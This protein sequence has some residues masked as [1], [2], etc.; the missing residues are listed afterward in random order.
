MLIDD[1]NIRERVHSARDIHRIIDA[2]HDHQ[3]SKPD[4]V[5]AYALELQILIGARRGEIPPLRREDIN[6]GCI[7]IWQEQ[8]TVKAHDGIPEKDLI[9]SHTKTGKNRA[10]PIDDMTQDLLDRLF[11]MLDEYYPDTEY[12]F[13]ANTPNGVISNATV[14][15]FYYRTC[16]KLGIKISRETVKGTHSFRRNAITSV[17]NQTGNIQMTAEMFGNSPGVIA[18]NYFT[19]IDYDSARTALNNRAYLKKA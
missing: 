12:L 1:V 2:V 9:V 6:N 15:L 7:D 5:P 4:Y 18:S 11:K 16:K 13:P 8:I 19:G 10:F 14:Y 17:V 3:K